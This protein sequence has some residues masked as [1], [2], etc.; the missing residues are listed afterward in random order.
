MTD[1]P[2]EVAQTAYDLTKAIVE[3]ASNYGFLCVE[4]DGQEVIV[5]VAFDGAA[6]RL[7]D[8][9]SLSLESEQT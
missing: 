7:N 5:V 4:I 9:M 8:L 2:A 1:L 6:R 3:K